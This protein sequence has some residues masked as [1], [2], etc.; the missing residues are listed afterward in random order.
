MK[1]PLFFAAL[2]C[3]LIATPAI[4][5]LGQ[6]GYNFGQDVRVT[7]TVSLGVFWDSNARDTATNEE[8]GSGWTFRPTLSLVKQGRLTNLSISGFYTME[9]GFDSDDALDSD[10]YG[11]S[12]GL[13]RELT[14]H[15]TLTVS[16]A[17]SR[18]E[19]DEFYQMWNSTLGQLMDT[20]DKDKQESYSAN[21][22]LGYQNAKWQWSVGTGWSRSKYLEGN[23]HHSDTYSLV[24][25]AGRAISA[26]SYWN[27]S[28]STSWDDSSAAGAGDDQGY[29]I[30]TGVSGAVTNRTTYN[31]MVGVG[32]YDFD[33][34]YGS[35]T[36]V[37]PT[38]NVGMAYK[39]NRTFAFSLAMS[40]RYEPEYGGNLQSYYIWSHHLT[41]AVNAQW[42]DKLSSRLNVSWVYEDHQAEDGYSGGQGDY[43]RTYYQFAFNT[44]YSFT[45]NAAV[46][47]GI[48]W[49]IDDYGSNDED[50]LRLDLGLT[51]TF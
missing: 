6:P 30:M 16:A 48:S 51:Y 17:Y 8:S 5:R 46:Y 28:F 32:I 12:L 41:G 14:K 31:A 1:K 23:K 15:Y 18:S 22:A 25:M 9:R 43:D 2:L 33:G 44:R 36:E 38:Y 34:E 13:S 11:L 49:A 7:P 20:V 26:Q 42:T 35:Q 29:Y 40:S 27:L 10:S 21:V 37:G 4:A 50:S 47:G 39:A 3:G 45:P 24:A 19:N